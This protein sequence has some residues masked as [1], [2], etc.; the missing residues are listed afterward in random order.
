[1]SFLERAVIV[2]TI[3]YPS[4]ALHM[5]ARDCP[6]WSLIV[7]GDR[8]T[9][10]DWSLKGATYLS[11]PDQE[12][13]GGEFAR[14]SPRDHYCRK[15]VGYLHA[16]REGAQVIAETDDDNLPY[17]SFLRDVDQVVSGRRI[18]EE[19]CQNVYT[20]F[21][22]A[23]IWPRG[24]PLELITPSLRARPSLGPLADFDCP[25]QQFLADGDP[26]V[27]AVYRLT[28]D[29]EVVFD[30]DANAVVLGPGTFCPFNSQNTIW[31][32]DAFPLLYLP[33]FV[34]FRM[35]DIWRSFV[36]Q[37]CLYAMRKH[38]VF[39]AATV[40]QER[41]AH[42]LLRDFEDEVPG[43]LH[44]QRILNLLQGL[45]LSS[46]PRDTAENLLL[47]YKALVREGLVPPEELRL[48][49]LW[50]KALPT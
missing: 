16:M 47:C 44:N 26:D 34:S 2:T 15:N 23:P 7:V 37:V 32:P 41:N 12:E 25:V 9:P 43:Y 10:P 27:D 39:R 19:G 29:R 33:N 18:A 40:R 22:K 11:I 42:S 28:T 17:R 49:G 8:K 4:V 14:E 1:M 36:A 45:T 21:T 38:L 31:W 24:F 35:T 50:L 6:D 5:I 20:C 48:L 46:H 3:N 30:A 13:L